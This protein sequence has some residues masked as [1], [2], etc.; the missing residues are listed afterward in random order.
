[1]SIAL[2]VLMHIVV[3]CQVFSC[4]TSCCCWF[5]LAGKK[6]KPACKCVLVY[7]PTILNRILCYR[8]LSLLFLSFPLPV[9]VRV[10]SLVQVAMA[11]QRGPGSRTR[12]PH[13]YHDNLIIVC[14]QD[15]CYFTDRLVMLIGPFEGVLHARGRELEASY[16]L[17]LA[18]YHGP[19]GIVPAH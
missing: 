4:F 18:L 16:A 6:I 9:C 13:S 1:M 15:P 2:F 5:S 14:M 19:T 7:T 10:G 3:V 12:G 8:S 11:T 17:T